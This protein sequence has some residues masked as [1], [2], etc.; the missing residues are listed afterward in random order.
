[1]LLGCIKK[2]LLINLLINAK[3]GIDNQVIILNL[4]DFKSP[5]IGTVILNP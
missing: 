3:I 1:M 5:N 4:F 2:L